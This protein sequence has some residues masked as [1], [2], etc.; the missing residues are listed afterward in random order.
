MSPDVCMIY[1]LKEL[2]FPLFCEM[3]S[4]AALLHIELRHEL[5]V[6]LQIRH[7]LAASFFPLCKFVKMLSQ[8]HKKKKRKQKETIFVIKTVYQI[9]RGYIWIVGYNCLCFKTACSSIIRPGQHA[10]WGLI[11]CNVKFYHLPP[12]AGAI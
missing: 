8:V 2:I 3:V 10:Q 6:S 7:F 4:S 12:R 5:K 9:R 1:N 11:L